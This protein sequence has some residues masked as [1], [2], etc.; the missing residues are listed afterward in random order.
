M[1]NQGCQKF[2]ACWHSDFGSSVVDCLCAQSPGVGAL[3]PK[4]KQK[5]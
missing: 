1:N 4:L 3:A 5:K 2:D